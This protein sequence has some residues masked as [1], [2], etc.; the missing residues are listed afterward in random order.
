MVHLCV[1]I[2]GEA[3]IGGPVQSRWMYPI[4]RFLGKLKDYVRNKARPEGSIAEGYI[5]EE[6]LFF[7]S[8]Y[9]HNVETKSNQQE[10][11]SD[12]VSDDYEGLSIFAPSGVPLGK[13]NSKC[14]TQEEWEKARDYVLKNCDEVQPFLREYE[15]GQNENEFSEWFRERVNSLPDKHTQVLK[16]LRSLSFGPLMGVERYNGYLANGFRFHI[17]ALEERRTNQNSGI[18]VEGASDARNLDYYGVLTEIISLQYLDGKRVVLFNSH[19]WDVSNFG[20]GIKVDKHN[21]V[22]VNTKRKLQT[23]EPF[24]LACQAQ[25]VFYVRDGFDPNW[26]VAIRTQARHSYDVVLEKFTM[27]QP[28][29]RKEF[30]LRHMNALYRDYRRKLKAIYYDDPK[31]INQVQREKNK[32]KNVARRDWLYLCKLWHSPDFKKLS[33]RN[34]KNRSR[35]KIPHYS[36]T[37]SFARIA[38][39][40]KLNREPTRAEILSKPV[41][42]VKF[43]ENQEIVSKL[44]NSIQEREDG[45]NNM[46]D[47]QIFKEILGEEKHGYLRAYGRN[48]SI[49]DHFKEKPSRINL[50]NQV[51]KIEK[52]A[53]ER[54]EEVKKAMEE[55]I[56]EKLAERDQMWEERFK[57][58]CEKLGAPSTNHDIIKTT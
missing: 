42:P 56:E 17:K 16:D 46:S 6:C 30:I 32:P 58:L 47:E 19:W 43:A 27:D 53:D 3:K 11:N 40:L 7:C 50:A 12:S 14:L 54:V 33:Q 34:R 52:K 48:K 55:K 5:L 2:V 29:M 38:D 51:I 21:I 39:E 15:Q 4:E 35:L 28:E 18:L 10:R 1:H 24:V 41:D 13:E 20:K 45:H 44:K 57:K 31:L 37:K 23:H 49:T 25:Q 9:L 36:G 22:S 26:L 8:K